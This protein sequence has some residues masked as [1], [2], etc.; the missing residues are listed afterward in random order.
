MQGLGKS[1]MN[2]LYGVPI[3]RNIIESYYCISQHWM[4]TEFDANVIDYWKR[5]I[6]SYVVKMKKDEGS[7]DECDIKNIYLLIWERLY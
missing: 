6:G 5:P 1:I 2:I 7:D 4:E 3:R